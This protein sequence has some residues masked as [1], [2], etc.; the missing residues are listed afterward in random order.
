VRPQPGTFVADDEA[1]P[2]TTLS[3]RVA[4]GVLPMGV[5]VLCNGCASPVPLV[6][7]VVGPS[8]ARQVSCPSCSADVVL[9]DAW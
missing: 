6:L 5:S 7:F 8:P 2:L 3:A 4:A 1:M 9:H